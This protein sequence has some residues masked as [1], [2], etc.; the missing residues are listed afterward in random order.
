MLQYEANLQSRPLHVAPLAHWTLGQIILMGQQPYLNF[1]VLNSF[2]TDLGYIYSYICALIL[3]VIAF[4]DLYRI[5]FSNNHIAHQLSP[6][7]GMC[8]RGRRK[9][10]QR[11]GKAGDL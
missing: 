10:V 11:N 3:Y 1:E 9:M 2:R 6:K 4:I 8:S 7:R 5:S